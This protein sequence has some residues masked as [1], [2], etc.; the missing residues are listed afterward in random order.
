M[1]TPLN[2]DSS[3]EDIDFKTVLAK[4]RRG[5]GSLIGGGEVAATLGISIAF[6]V[7]FWRAPCPE[8]LATVW[9]P[10]LV[11]LGGGLFGISIAALAIM[12]GLL[13]KEWLSVLRSIKAIPAIF[14]PFWIAAV[15][16]ATVTL[17]GFALWGLGTDVSLAWP[18]VAMAVFAG[19][20]FG[21]ALAS[22]LGLF[23]SLI[24]YVRLLAAGRGG[25][26]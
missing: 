6:G 19:A 21:E 1:V 23:G 22:T 7:V 24:R 16:W 3:N 20:A 9:G 13:D 17:S 10:S 18:V 15:L 26:Q 12:G 8:Q 14:A 4:F 2:T 5:G 25:G 11:T